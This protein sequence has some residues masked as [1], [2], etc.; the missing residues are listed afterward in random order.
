LLPTLP[1][2]AAAHGDVR[3]TIGTIQ[4]EQSV[5]L[6]AE[7]HRMVRFDARRF[8]QLRVKNP[9]WSRT[10]EGIRVL[11]CS[12]KNMLKQVGRRCQ[13]ASRMALLL[14]VSSAV[15]QETPKAN[16]VV[17]VPVVNMYRSASADIDVVSQSI[18][19]STVT[20]LEIS[21][22]WANIRTFDDYTGWVPLSALRERST[23]YAS[24]GSTVRVGQRSAHLYREPSVTTHAPLLTLPFDS[25]LEVLL[26]S[27]PS[28]RWIKVRLADGG[29]AYV[30]SGDVSSDVSAIDI[31]QMIALAKKFLGV[32]YTWGGSSSFGFDCSGFTQ[33]LERQRGVVIPR[34]ADLQA[35]W[36]GVIAVERKDLQA[37]DL[38]FFGTS[39]GHITHTGL[40]IGGGEF[41]HDTTHE[42]PGVQ[43]SKLDDVPWTTL[44][45][46]A[47]R[48]K[49]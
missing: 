22:D 5:E 47:R 16:Y 36:S 44:L 42:H 21:A 34:D 33:M 45:V 20:I 8:P 9:S 12:D 27:N 29:E 40:Y 49:P 6:A 17:A 38:L 18:Y 10:A 46:A 26:A 15:A 24:G 11:E 35:D 48:V 25:R 23:P 32:T 39:A 37:G 13:T 1:T 43:I 4:V 19:G 41:I 30:Q 31:E 7:E 14:L 28:E 2:I 3:G